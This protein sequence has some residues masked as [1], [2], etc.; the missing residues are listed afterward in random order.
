MLAIL[1]D[2]WQN[3]EQ[4]RDCFEVLARAVPRCSRLGYLEREAREE[5]GG[6]IEKVGEMGL[7]GHVR[8]MLC[9]MATRCEDEEMV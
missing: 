8:T 5:L 7:H 9:E 4:Y 1:A 3:A 2:R 6:L